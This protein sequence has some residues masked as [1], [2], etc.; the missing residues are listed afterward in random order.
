MEFSWKIAGAFAFGLMLGWNVYFV[1]R[2]RKGDIGFSDI[3][4]LIGA[5][6]GAAVLALYKA[7]TDLFG[8][9]GLGLGTGFFI[10]YISLLI[11][12]RVSPNFD[13]DWFL[14]GR[15]VNPAENQGYGADARPTLAPMALRPSEPERPAASPVTVVF[16]GANPGV[17]D[18]GT[19]K[20][21]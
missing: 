19:P 10:Y 16:H 9:Y 12:V 8:A 17:A 14:D 13:S 4:A 20:R 1:N 11:M 21:K 7:D 2:Y 5:V 6:G 15:R 3:T 18:D